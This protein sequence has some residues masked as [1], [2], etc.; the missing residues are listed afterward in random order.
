MFFFVDKGCNITKE[1][2]NDEEMLVKKTRVRSNSVER[3]EDS[4]FK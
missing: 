2:V 4:I 3:D 1:K